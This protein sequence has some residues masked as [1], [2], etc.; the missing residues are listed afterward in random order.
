MEAVSNILRAAIDLKENEREF[1]DSLFALADTLEETKVDSMGRGIV[2]YWPSI[3]FEG[4]EGEDKE[5][6]DD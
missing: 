1:D 5:S 4:E 2:M 6:E 3:A